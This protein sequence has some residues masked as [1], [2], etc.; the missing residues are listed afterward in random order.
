MEEGTVLRPAERWLVAVGFKQ[1]IWIRRHAL[2]ELK[3]REVDPELSP[4]TVEAYVVHTV[5]VCG[6]HVHAMDRLTPGRC[7][8]RSVSQAQQAQG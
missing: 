6:V 3:R 8:L 7:P 5:C 4:D 1:A 2:R